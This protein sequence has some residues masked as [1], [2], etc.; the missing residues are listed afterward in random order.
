M[1]GQAFEPRLP[2]ETQARG[3]LKVE[4]IRMV[5][6]DEGRALQFPNGALQDRNLSHRIA[7]DLEF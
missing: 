1:N 7:G 6:M 4:N 5:R 2:L 3:S